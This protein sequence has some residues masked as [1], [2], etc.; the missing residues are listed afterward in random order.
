MQGGGGLARTVG[1]GTA[2]FAGFG[3]GIAAA[4]VAYLLAAPVWVLPVAAIGTWGATQLLLAYPSMKAREAAQRAM[5]EAP[6]Y[7]A[8]IRAVV[9]SSQRILALAQRAA[10]PLVRQRGQQIVEA[11]GRVVEHLRDDPDD[12]LTSQKFLSVYIQRT[13]A[14]MA[15]YLQ[16]E[17][18]RTPQAETVRRKVRDELL[19]LLLQL[20]EAQLQRITYD[21]L[22]ALE[23]DIDVLTK[24]IS[25][26]GR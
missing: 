26:E 16:Y 6:D 14:I 15:R 17:S 8:E 23:T 9:D 25:L 13:L 18:V 19:P 10:D 20:C 2:L 24:S 11:L 4:G 1:T 3:A 5:A 12:L 22:R 21:D 7:D